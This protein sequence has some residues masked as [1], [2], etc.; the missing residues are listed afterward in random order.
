MQGVA[1][2]VGTFDFGPVS[3][4][5]APHEIVCLVGANGAGKTTLINLGLG[6][7]SP[8]LGTVE[9]VGRDPND[10]DRRCMASVGYVPD[11]PSMLVEEL[12]ASEYW[13]LGAALIERGDPGRSAST[14]VDRAMNMAS[15]MGFD[16]GNKRISSFSHGMRKQTQ[17]V[18][19]FAPHHQL[20]V[21]DELANGLDP[22]VTRSVNGLLAERAAAGAGV[23][24]STHDLA[25]AERIAHRIVIM[26]RGRVL[27][28]GSVESLKDGSNER[29]DDVFFRLV[30]SAT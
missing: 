13:A 6:L 21:V 25:W 19:A 17:I 2:A 7:R 10:Q 20:L 27:A 16:P 1:A 9:L 24:C 18:S 30:D 15:H 14:I 8:S 5:V 29:L 26:E 23:L 11:D 4:T 3:L 12:T 22:I 28:S